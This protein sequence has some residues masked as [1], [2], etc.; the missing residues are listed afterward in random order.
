MNADKRA[1]IIQAVEWHDRDLLGEISELKAE[2]ARLTTL[3][4]L[5]QTAATR[6]RQAD[7]EAK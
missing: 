2:V 3:V 5:H 7:K 6:D 4:Q 1:E